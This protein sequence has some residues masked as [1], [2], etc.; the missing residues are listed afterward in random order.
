MTM[1][2][3]II[4]NGECKDS[5]YLKNFAASFDKIICAD[6]GYLHAVAAGL[7]VDTVVG[8]FDSSNC[9]SGVESVVFPKEKDLSDAEIAIEYALEKFGENITLVCSLGERL[10]HQLFNV[11]L[12][13]K[14]PF[15]RIEESDVLA[16]LCDGYN[17][18]SEFENK[19]ISFFPTE[20]SNITLGGFKY[21]LN[22]CD[23]IPG[24]TVTLSNIA[25]KNAVVRVNSGRVIAIIN[26]INS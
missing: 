11:F 13:I 17:N 20:K 14:Y 24:E 16:F 4:L 1:K 3:L 19:T 6:G 10:D 18:F 12:M 21:N 7:K 25:L 15:L 8:D 9:P 23:I 22:N 26:K 2:T 5:T